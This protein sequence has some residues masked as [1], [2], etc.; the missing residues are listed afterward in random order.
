[1]YDPIP[2][3]MTCSSI[4]SGTTAMPMQEIL[5]I[6]VGFRSAKRFIK[7]RFLTLRTLN[8]KLYNL[9]LYIIF[10]VVLKAPHRALGVS[11]G[12]DLGQSN[13]LCTADSRR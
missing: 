7:Y 3:I 6:F 10:L 1:M 8:M 12:P 4:K 2:L 13:S 9:S 11:L 5:R